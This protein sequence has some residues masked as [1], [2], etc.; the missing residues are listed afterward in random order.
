MAYKLEQHIMRADEAQ[1]RLLFEAS[2]L[3]TWIID[4]ATGRFLVVNDAAIRQYGYSR[5]EFHSMTVDA[6]RLP[7]S[8]GRIKDELRSQVNVPFVIAGAWEHRRKDGIVFAVEVRA[9][10]ITFAGAPALLSVVVDAQ[11]EE[12]VAALLQRERQLADAQA[13]AHAGSWEW[14]VR[15]DVVT[16]SRELFRIY[17][18]D[19]SAMASPHE[20]LSRV[21]PDERARVSQTIASALAGRQRRFEFECRLLLPG[22]EVR[23][24]HARHVATF[25]ASGPVHV[26][27]T[28]QDITDRRRAR[29]ALAESERHDRELIE[30]A[31]DMVTVLDAEG[32]ITYSSPSVE[33]QLGHAPAV[34][35][36]QGVL[37]F[38]HPEDRPRMS[39]ALRMDLARPGIPQAFAFRFQHRDGSWRMLEAVG[40]GSL[41]RRNAMR[42]VV[43]A[44]DVTDRHEAAELQSALRGELAA[45]RLPAVRAAQLARSSAAQRAT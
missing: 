16:W 39:E 29:P 37:G 9:A 19:P 40:Q 12:A 21:H 43:N 11:R 18:V 24:L 15:A 26:S 42:I 3:P 4:E 14:N 1:Y 35:V 13:I 45:A 30:N 10:R 34:L 28:V 31:T 22:G 5:E 44:R 8:H 32:T 6:I 38:V 33:R 17:G 41:E 20:F 7:H 23:R 27:G 25:D 2:P 36:G